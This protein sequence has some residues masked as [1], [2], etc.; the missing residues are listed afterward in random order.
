MASREQPRYAASNV[1]L[2]VALVTTGP[3]DLPGAA[4][5][6]RLRASDADREHVI[7][8]LK[9]AFVQGR[10]TK[11][12]LDLRAGQ[13]FAS[14]TY[15]ELAALTVDIPAGPPGAGRLP[16]PA[17]VATRQVQRVQPA[18]TAADKK[19]A[20]WALVACAHIP[21]FI[22]VVAIITGSSSL[23]QAAEPMMY[24]YFL[25]VMMA[26]AHLI[27][28]RLKKHARRPVPGAVPAS[29]GHRAS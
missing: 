16:R 18:R 25:F 1:L 24:A 4:R 13:T 14:R 6:G 27:D 20:T 19:A 5:R 9:V 29:L 21:V 7:E 11:D 23:A 17:P 26:G 15:A 8:T 2:E 12:E 3:P 22:I 10:L 28:S